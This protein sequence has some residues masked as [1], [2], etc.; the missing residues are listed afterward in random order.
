MVRY[1]LSL[2]DDK[3]AN[4]KPVKGE[5]VPAPKSKE[6]L[7]YFLGQL[8]RPW[9]WRDGPLTATSSVA[10]R[11]P[12][13]KASTYDEGKG[14]SRTKGA[15]GADVVISNSTQSYIAFNNIDLNGI[16]KLE[17]TPVKDAK[18]AGGKVEVRLGSPTGALIGEAEIKGDATSP[19]EVPLRQP[20]GAAQTVYFVFV[21]PSAGT[22]ALLTIDTIQFEGDSM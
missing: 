19:V 20:G 13:V 18:A 14:V 1:I 22:K 9:Q 10:L 5:Y 6:R 21:N 11:N 16:R 15:S 17:L 7:V 3:S 2:A 8:H 12:K 4:K